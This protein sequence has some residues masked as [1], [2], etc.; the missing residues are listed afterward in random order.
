[1][2]IGLREVDGT[3][4]VPPLERFLVGGRE[5]DSRRGWGREYGRWVACLHIC[6]TGI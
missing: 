4:S 6:Y 3:Y 5:V 1:M 2:L